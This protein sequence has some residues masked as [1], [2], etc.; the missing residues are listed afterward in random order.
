MS[1]Y[2]KTPSG[3]RVIQDPVPVPEAPA[4]APAVLP[5]EQ[6]EKATPVLGAPF[7]PSAAEAAAEE[8]PAAAAEAETGAE[9]AA[10]AEAAVEAAAEEAIVEAIIEETI[11]EEAVVEEE[12]SSQKVQAAAFP[13]MVS[14]Q[15]ICFG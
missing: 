7:E 14:H 10:A 5:T 12:M 1:R 2:Q 15:V 3:W 8:K 11:V 9:V 4:S 13:T 6:R